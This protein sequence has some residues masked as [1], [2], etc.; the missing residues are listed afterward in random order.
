M[1]SR[2]A[3]MRNVKRGRVWVLRLVISLAVTGCTVN[4]GSTESSPSESEDGAQ[5][6]STLADPVATTVQ[7]E[8]DPE[9]GWRQLVE[10]ENAYSAG[11]LSVL[12]D[13]VFGLMAAPDLRM[14]QFLNGSWQ[15]ITDRV[16]ANF[17]IP[18]TGLDYDIRIQ[19]VL[20]TNDDAVDYVVNYT[21]APWHV[22]DAPNQGRDRGTVLSGQDG[23]WRSVAFVDPYG[24]GN[25]YTS[26][27]TI[28]YENGAL[29]GNY[30]GSCGRPCGLLVYS[31]VG[32][33]E[34]LE[35]L[36]ATKRQSNALP[37][38][39]CA[40]FSYNETLPLKRC[41]EGFPVQVVQ[42]ALNGLGYELEADGYFGDGTLFAVQHFQRANFVR[43]SG[44]VDEPT[45]RV[46][47]AAGGLP[48]NDLNGDGLVT[49]NEFSGD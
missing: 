8:V 25:E 49:P 11:E 6:A 39:W 24:D 35:G 22:L 23:S 42:D 33:A 30:Y 32:G 15:E 46:L 3:N 1:G 14:F 29:F 16:I 20:I 47:F 9:T 38:P 7:A 48:G 13:G 10:V 31:W 4:V 40:A 2:C 45:W 5:T 41:D 37:K 43:A 18:R 34:R 28:R 21:P 36:E 26:V 19:S 44:K 17:D 27:E 12:P